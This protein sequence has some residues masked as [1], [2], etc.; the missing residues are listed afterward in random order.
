M[1]SPTLSPGDTAWLL[2]ASTLVMLMTVPGL[3]LFYSGLV[4]KKMLY[5]R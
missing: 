2:T 3:A 1:A 5:Q 4:R